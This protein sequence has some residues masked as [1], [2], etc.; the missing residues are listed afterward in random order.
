M[1]PPAQRA[2]VQ[3]PPTR[4]PCHHALTATS[5]CSALA[6]SIRAP[7]SDDSMSF[8]SELVMVEQAL[9]VDWALGGVLLRRW[10]GA[11]GMHACGFVLVH[12]NGR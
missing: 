4:R 8:M 3:Q 11:S 1:L 12:G 9:C 5:A 7:A 10:A 6:F 2:H